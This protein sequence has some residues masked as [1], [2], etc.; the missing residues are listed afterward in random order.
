MPP[1]KKSAKKAAKKQPAK[2]SAKKA[3]AKKSAK[4]Q[5][6]AR[7]VP[8]YGVLRGVVVAH[9]R[10][11]G[12]PESPHLQLI[13]V[14]NGQRWR[15][16]VN[17]LS[18]DKKASPD[19][20]EVR[21]AIIDPLVGHPILSRLNDL[22]EGFTPLRDRRPGQTLDF[23]REPLFAFEDMRHLPFFS[24][25]VGDDLQDLLE[26]YVDKAEGRP[27]QEAEVFVWGSKFSGDRRPPDIQFDT[28]QGVHNIHMNQGN[29]RDGGHA[30][31][32]GVFQDGGLIFRFADRFVG[33]FLKFESQSFQTDDQ[34][35]MPLEGA[36]PIVTPRP[37]EQPPVRPLPPISSRPAV[38]IVAALVNPEGEEIGN[39]TVTLI[40]TLGQPINL[41][42]WTIEDRGGQ[43]DSLDGV[44]LR[45][46]EARLI[47]LTG[48]GARLGNQGGAI[49]LKDRDGL[50]VHSVT[51]SQ[52][53]AREQGRTIL[54]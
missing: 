16:A 28:R 11:D 8:S 46:G 49:T 52:E 5:T 40:N 20:K 9:G 14:A 6:Q 48:E 38:A 53:D 47:V 17:V 27:A 23:V 45:G 19:E 37:G 22:A 26:V 4:K 12:D 29:P 24:P 2:K 15:C 13:V 42:G 33:V 30:G 3:A 1:K 31:D 43:S 35:G 36:P 34:T 39:E 54:F 18:S 41:A 51:Y 7:G 25:G 50:R 10:E 32:N 44:Q 21:F